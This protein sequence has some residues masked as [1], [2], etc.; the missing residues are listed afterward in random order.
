[1]PQVQLQWG[2]ATHIG[3]R[4]ENQDRLLA[5][6][7]VFAVA[8]G[9]GGHA[10]GAEAAQTAIDCLAVLGGRPWVTVDELQAAVRQADEDIR[11]LGEADPSMV[12][13]GSTLAGVAMV[14]SAD[15]LMWAVFHIGDSRVYC[16]TP[17]AWGQVTVDHSLVQVLVDSGHVAPENAAT[18]PQ[19]NIVTRALGV[20]SGGDAAVSLLPVV[21]GQ[22]FLICSDGLSN[23][24]A[25]DRLAALLGSEAPPEPVARQLVDQA[26][27]NDGRDNIAAV[28]VHAT[29]LDT[30][31]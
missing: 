31:P 11:A 14:Q 1:M 10:A 6:P 2:T 20:G 3:Q 12:G 23:E 5:A 27:A 4:E 30:E 7:P 9:M 24:V 15:E 29:L 19:R 21:A 26:V 18:H 16:W 17:S 25:E 28:L 22:R 13:A 8:D